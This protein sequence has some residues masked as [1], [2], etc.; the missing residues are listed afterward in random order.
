MVTVEYRID[1]ARAE[2]FREA[3]REVSME[4]RRHGAVYWH[5]YVDAEDPA[6]YVEVFIVASWLEHLRQHERVTVAD[7]DVEVI[8]RAFHV[9]A[10]PP[11]I[12]HF[13]SGL[14]GRRSPAQGP[15]GTV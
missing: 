2:E 11:L 14:E 1:L 4:R 12:S 7:R 5:V 8:A 9:G 6:R 15:D 3:M 13:V 10:A